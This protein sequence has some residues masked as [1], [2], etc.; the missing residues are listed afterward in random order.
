LADQFDRASNNEQRD[1]EFALKKQQ[2]QKE[3]PFI[4][5]GVRHC[6]DCSGIILSARIKSV[7]A[8][9]CIDCQVHHEALQKH[10]R[11]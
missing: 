2:Q 10:Q 5:F 7:N 8:V 11:N 9:R 3:K 1:R 4:L 6:L